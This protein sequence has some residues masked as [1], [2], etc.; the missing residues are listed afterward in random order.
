MG[1]FERDLLMEIKRTGETTEVK[2]TVAVEKN[3]TK[4]EPKKEKV[5]NFST[6]PEKAT[7]ANTD[8]LELNTKTKTEGAKEPTDVEAPKAEKKS[9]NWFTAW[10]RDED[11]VSTDGQDDGK[12]SFWESA[13]SI[14]K[15]FI[16]IV[17]GVINHPI[18][19]GATIAAAVGLNVLT[20]GAALPIMV[21]LGAVTGAGLIGVGAY[22]AATAKTDGEAKNAFEKVGGGIFAL[23]GSFLG[24]K[25]ALNVASKAGVQSA[26]GAQNMNALQATW[27]SIKSTPEALKVSASNIK[28]NVLTWTTG[29]IHPNSNFMRKDVYHAYSKP[30]EPKVYRFNPNGT[31]DEILA[32]N[33]QVQ[34]D[35][36]ANKYYIQTSWGEKSYIQPGKEYMI[37]E[38]GPGDF[39][40][41]EGVEFSKTYV[42]SKVFAQTGAREYIDP[43]TLE[44]GKWTTAT[45]QA[46]V[47][48]KVVP[49]GTKY[50]SA[51]G[52]HTMQKNSVMMIDGQGRPYQNE[53]PKLVG[54]NTDFS[55]E[56]VAALKKA[57]PDVPE[58]Q[59]K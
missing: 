20:G 46:P 54:R 49:E 39:N 24:A 5:V 4:N 58:L 34:Y 52:V 29:T 6:N 18:M 8:K 19:T 32:N 11:K 37:A 30:N 55:P 51:E 15:G 35:A 26:K 12:L 47:S 45:K 3:A 43:A 10:L 23:A 1:I 53:I 14:G 41:I 59:A 56:A 28:G 22:G 27:Q 13:K 42:N 31:P 21:A 33:P 38:Y 48:F 57:A 2:Q 36:A 17:K 25:S 9:S 50:V 16:G 7:E 40:A 44:Y